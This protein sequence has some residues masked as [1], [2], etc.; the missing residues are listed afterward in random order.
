LYRFNE[1]SWSPEKY[2]IPVDVTWSVMDFTHGL[3]YGTFKKHINSHH[4][5]EQAIERLFLPEIIHRW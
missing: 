1:F 5:Y 4:L 3:C 2:D